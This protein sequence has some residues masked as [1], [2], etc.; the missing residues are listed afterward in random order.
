MNKKIRVNR[1]LT[2][3]DRELVN[4]TILDRLQAENK[5]LKESAKMCIVTCTTKAD[6]KEILKLQAQATA[7]EARLKNM[8]AGDLSPESRLAGYSVIV[9]A[10]K[11]KQNQL[12]AALAEKTEALEG[13][14]GKAEE[15]LIPYIKQGMAHDAIRV[16]NG[17][18]LQAKQALQPQ[19]CKTCDGSKKVINYTDSEKEFGGLET[20]SRE[21]RCPD[22]K[23]VEN[24]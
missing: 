19:V 15:G 8:Y 22:C 13:I 6:T 4:Q 2:P 12:Q 14:V 23:E 24:E 11:K 5:E 20:T 16:A 21:V 1:H 17:I 10:I 9:E 7:L 3:R 18:I